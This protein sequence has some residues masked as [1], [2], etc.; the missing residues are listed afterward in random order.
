ML[1]AGSAYFPP[2]ARDTS[3]GDGLV[4]QCSW[5]EKTFSLLIGDAM[6]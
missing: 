3:D 1:G 5:G 2:L 4:P 6:E